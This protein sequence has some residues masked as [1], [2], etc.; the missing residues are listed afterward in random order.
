MIKVFSGLFREKRIETLNCSVA[1]D[2]ANRLSY[3]KFEAIVLDC[4]RVEGCVDL[5]RT[6]P[7]P[8]KNVMAVVIADDYGKREDASRNGASFVN[9]PATRCARDPKPITCSLRA[10]ATGPA[11]IFQ[12]GSRA[13]CLNP[14]CVGNSRAMPH[15]ES[16]PKRYGTK[17]S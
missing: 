13:A 4:D 10:N 6:L 1:I 8:H 14:D 12:I 15:H 11:R 2:A 17:Y 7:G 9:S 3:E 5:L 16:K